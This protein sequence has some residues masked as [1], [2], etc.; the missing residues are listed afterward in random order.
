MSV[1]DNQTAK[2][3]EYTLLYEIEKCNAGT[4]GG[5]YGKN[6]ELNGNPCV[7]KYI[8]CHTSCYY[9]SSKNLKHTE[10][11][12]IPT[13]LLTNELVPFCV[14]T[15]YNLN[16]TEETPTFADVSVYLNT[17]ESAKLGII[18]RGFQISYKIYGTD[19]L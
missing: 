5:T 3:R 6:I 18:A 10:T 14:L 12:I 4:S 8:V 15:A 13:C 11:R 2:K 9:Q 17:T 7:Y 16:V 1:K 19:V